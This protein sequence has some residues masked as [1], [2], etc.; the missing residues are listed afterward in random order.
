MYVGLFGKKKE[1]MSKVKT[2]SAFTLKGLEKQINKFGQ[3]NEIVDISQDEN[4]GTYT[5][6]VRYK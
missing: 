2:F 1:P 3:K 4:H 5:A 6:I